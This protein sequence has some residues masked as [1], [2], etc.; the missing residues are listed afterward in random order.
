MICPRCKDEWP[1]YSMWRCQNCGTVY[2]PS[3]GNRTD[4]EIRRGNRGGNSASEFCPVCRERE[5][6]KLS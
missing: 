3:C 1:K 4:D 5:G 6:K 2:C